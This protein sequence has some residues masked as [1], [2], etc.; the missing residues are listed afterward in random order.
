[1]FGRRPPDDEPHVGCLDTFSL[2]GSGAASR[3]ISGRG[4]DSAFD[5]FCRSPWH[6]STVANGPPLVQLLPGVDVLDL[7]SNSDM[8]EVWK[9]GRTLACLVPRA[10]VGWEFYSLLWPEPNGTSPLRLSSDIEILIAREPKG[11]IIPSLLFAFVPSNH[12]YDAGGTAAPGNED[13]KSAHSRSAIA[14]G[15]RQNMLMGRGAMKYEKASGNLNTAFRSVTARVLVLCPSTVYRDSASLPADQNWGLFIGPRNRS[16]VLLNK[17]RGRIDLHLATLL[18]LDAHFRMCEGF[19][20]AMARLFAPF[21]TQD[22]VPALFGWPLDPLRIHSGL[23]NSTVADHVSVQ[24][25]GREDYQRHFGIRLPS[26]FLSNASNNLCFLTPHE[27]E[28]QR[29]EDG[30]ARP[31]LLHPGPLPDLPKWTLSG[32]FG[33]EAQ[34]KLVDYRSRVQPRPRD[35]D[36]GG[37]GGLLQHLLGVHDAV[38]SD[39]WI[40]KLVPGIGPGGCTEIQIGDRSSHLSDRLFIGNGAVPA[41]SQYP[42]ASRG[43][44]AALAPAVSP[45]LQ[46]GHH[47]GTLGSHPSGV[48]GHA[49]SPYPAPTATMLM[50]QD[51]T[52]LAPPG[53]PVPA[54]DH[55]YTGAQFG[56]LAAPP[57][58]DTGSGLAHILAAGQA[59]LSHLG[60]QQHHHGTATGGLVPGGEAEGASVIRGEH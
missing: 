49:A 7:Y 19:I 9:D 32:L 2:P 23:T 20:A 26:F 24:M 16:L 35:E 50:N 27:A 46:E 43:G 38:D 34:H 47:G 15:N 60:H 1:M 18:G 37:V 28:L 8:A 29:A 33:P 10:V 45:H 13:P 31:H 52:Q 55:G 54:S 6:K 59:A 56:A 21:G 57:A 48:P 51:G 42:H 12:Y 14:K 11:G 30:R 4:G 40:S 39:S 44:V 17:H 41:M 25:D 3:R 36:G 53:Q 22:A 58:G 5:D